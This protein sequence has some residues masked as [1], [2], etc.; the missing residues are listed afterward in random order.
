MTAF[1]IAIVGGGLSGLSLA[2]ALAPSGMRIAVLEAFDPRTMKEDLF[3]GRVSAIAYGSQQLFY[4]LG[5]WD[6]I[7]PNAGEIRDIRISDSDSRFFLH[8]DHMLAG[9][10]PMGYIVEN[11]H[12]RRPLLD[13]AASLENMDLL[14]PAS[15]VAINS[16]AHGITLHLENGK[17]LRTKLAVAADGKYSSLR[18]MAGIASIEH[19]YR[20]T[21][22]VCTVRH[23]KPHQQTAQEHFLPA[24]PFA[25][26][27]MKDE[28]LSS[29]VWTEKSELA[30]LFLAMNDEDFLAA[31]Q[32]RFG[33][34]LGTLAL[35]GPR[36]SYPLSLVYASRYT[37]PRFCLLGDAA[38]AIHP[39][40]GQG[41][42]LGLRDVAM[43]AE[44][45]AERF[46][47]GLDIGAK[48]ILNE[49][50]SLRKS[51][52]LL[53]IA[54]TDSLNRL[55]SNTIPPLAFA[56]RTGMAIVHHLPELKKYFIHHAMGIAGIPPE[57]MR[58]KPL[59]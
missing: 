6:K 48:T 14:A 8:Y 56:R 46:R 58:D 2:A 37:A 18:R 15:C 10:H 23:E 12:L 53:M 55:F 51:D 36:W 43:L 21:G 30:P 17:S 9:N 20:Q 45:L 59:S 52:N 57:L 26:L 35:F 3:D 16:D 11:R 50:E 27:P 44:L 34:Y 22:I 7:A 29:L 1:D 13:H 40:A 38:H 28:H 19:S 32:E 49:Y 42:N 5:L 4:A 47:L 31:I 39:I 54:V 41:F 33:A 24:G 25:I